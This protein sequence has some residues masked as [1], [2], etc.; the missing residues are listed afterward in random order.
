MV[1][2]HL[3]C[4]VPHP[5]AADELQA[6]RASLAGA[7]S[8]YRKSLAEVQ[9]EARQLRNRK[10]ELQRR[11]DAVRQGASKRDAE[12]VRVARGA[13]GCVAS[14]LTLLTRRLQEESTRQVQ[15]QLADVSDELMQARSSLA[16]FQRKLAREVSHVFRVG[17]GRR[18][19]PLHILTWVGD[20]MQETRMASLRDS[21]QALQAQIDQLES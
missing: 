9:T 12:D 1:P 8:R 6:L 15:R 4:L 11:L 13:C 20:R 16:S 19:T 21:K 2:Q 10:S 3:H 18:C 14:L 17:T 7:P 5:F